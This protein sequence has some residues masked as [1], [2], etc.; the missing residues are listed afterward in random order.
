MPLARHIAVYE[1]HV[2]VLATMDMGKMW[3]RFLGEFLGEWER[4]NRLNLADD[5]LERRMLAFIEDLSDAPVTDLA[6]QTSGV[7]YNQGRGAEILSAAAEGVVEFVVRSEVMDANT[8]E[9]CS[10]IDGAVFDAG[11]DDY[12]RWHPPAG[13]AGQDRCRGFYVPVAGGG[14]G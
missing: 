12:Y 3:D 10:Q 6:R 7:A 9:F 1:E 11:S 14:E 13:C 2:E 4:M 5:E 8:C